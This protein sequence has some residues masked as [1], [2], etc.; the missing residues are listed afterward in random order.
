MDAVVEFL[1]KYRPAA[2]ARGTLAYD[3][4]APVWLMLAMAALAAA[5]ALW[6]VARSG[7]SVTPLARLTLAS[8]RL[9]ALALLAWGLCR[10]VLVVAESLKQRNVVAVLVDDSRSMRIADV[11][12][13]PR[14]D[15][16]RRMAGGPARSTRPST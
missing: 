16:V 5:M 8:L 3:P 6:G 13:L 11:D 1:L 14:A 15:Q 10:P 7:R 12:G 9:G 4:V 2:F